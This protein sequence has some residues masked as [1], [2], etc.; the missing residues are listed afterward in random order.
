MLE[1]TRA[2]LRRFHARLRVVREQIRAIE[3]SRLGE[4]A[5]TPEKGPH[6]MVRLAV[7]PC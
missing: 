5:T 1:N 2:E 3:Q 6:A 4:L 7:L